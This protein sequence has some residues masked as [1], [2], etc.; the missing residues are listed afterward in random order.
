MNHIDWCDVL[1]I[2][3][4]WHMKLSPSLMLIHLL[5]RC[6]GSSISYHMTDLCGWASCTN[7]S[8]LWNRACSGQINLLMLT[9]LLKLNISSS[10]ERPQNAYGL[11]MEFDPNLAESFRWMTWG[12]RMG[13]IYFPV[14]VGSLHPLLPGTWFILT[15][16]N[17]SLTLECSYQV[18]SLT[19]Q[20]CVWISPLK[21]TFSPQ[22]LLSLW[23]LDTQRWDWTVRRCGFKFGMW[24]PR[25]IRTTMMEFLDYTQHQ[26]LPSKKSQLASFAIS[27]LSKI[28]WPTRFFT[29]GSMWLWSTGL[30]LKTKIWFIPERSYLEE[31]M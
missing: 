18:P 21:W 27:V 23:V 5:A 14:V 13:C 15:S 9:T 31:L 26:S 3:Q 29:A 1:N 25:L 16:T 8:I 24:K 22:F 12:G 17:P 4:V 10:A 19:I 20:T 7:A 2:R 30:A 28:L 6:A 11:K